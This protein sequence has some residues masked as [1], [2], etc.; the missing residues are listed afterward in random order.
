MGR[1]FQT[2]SVLC[3]MWLLIA[4]RQ[5][6]VTTYDMVREADLKPGDAIPS[7]TDETVLTVTGEITAINSGDSLSFDM[8]TL[9]RLGTV[10]YTVHDPWADADVTY[11]GVLVSDLLAVAGVSSSAT[12]L[13]LTALDDYE[14]DIPI[15]DTEKW[16]L[17]LATQ[18]NGEYMTVA[19][20]GPS[21]IIYP[22]H[23]FPELDSPTNQNLWIWNVVTI[24]IR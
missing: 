20:G 15:A 19:D 11:S 24:E 4:C 18:T 23:A 8:A 17:L 22:Y 2:L 21:R 13:H 12:S 10:Q 1:F 9:E 16:P 6:E 5:A 14:V 7:P 3:L